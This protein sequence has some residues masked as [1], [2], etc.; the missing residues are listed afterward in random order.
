MSSRR[1]RHRSRS[2]DRFT[3]NRTRPVDVDP[4]ALGRRIVLP[5]PPRVHASRE[6]H[7][8]LNSS[9][10]AAQGVAIEEVSSR[11]G[12]YAFDADCLPT[13]RESDDRLSVG[14]ERF[15]NVS[16]DES[17]RTSDENGTNR[18]GFGRRDGKRGHY[19]PCSR[20]SHTLAQATALPPIDVMTSC[21]RRPFSRK[22]SG[23]A[24]AIS[25]RIRS[26]P[27][28]SPCRTCQPMS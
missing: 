18:R 8:G 12:S 28:T 4:A 19:N 13:A 21:A 26:A 10:R 3:E 20:T 25:L 22:S 15:A 16:A 14:Y 11:R 6:M 17:A 5:F 24:W 9:E 1:A 2:P 23:G 7:H 27:S